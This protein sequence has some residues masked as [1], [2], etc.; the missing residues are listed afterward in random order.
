VRGLP[1]R[2]LGD[3][4]LT[5]MASPAAQLSDIPRGLLSELKSRMK[6]HN[7]LGL[8]APQLGWPLRVIVAQLDRAS[9][10]V[11]INPEIV[12]RSTD[13]DFRLE[14]CLSIP[15]VQAS[16]RRPT[17]IRVVYRDEHWAAHELP[18][19]GLPARVVQHEVDHLDGRMITDN[20][21]PQQRKAA[22]KCVERARRVS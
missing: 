16:I 6:L 14:G 3:P 5:A 2:L 12:E 19:V 8:A 1:I 22:L 17:S 4:I 11:M 7:A 13:T 15:G 21:S 9:L 10:A 20:L 18:L